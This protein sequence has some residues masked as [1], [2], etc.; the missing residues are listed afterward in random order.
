VRARFRGQG[1][2]TVLWARFL[3]ERVLRLGRV[4]VVLALPG[5]NSSS[6]PSLSSDDSEVRSSSLSIMLFRISE[7]PSC[8]VCDPGDSSFFGLELSEGFVDRAIFVLGPFAS[9]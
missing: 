9:V 5:V 7:N 3:D 8:S 1:S 2:L 4:P 6:Y